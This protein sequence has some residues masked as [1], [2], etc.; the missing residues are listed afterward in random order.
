M[1]L[2]EASLDKLFLKKDDPKKYRGPVPTRDAVL[3]QLANGLNHIHK[4]KLIHRDIKPQNVLIAI[5]TDGTTGRKRPLMKWADFGLSKQVN[6]NGSY[7][8]SGKRG[9]EGWFAPEISEKTNNDEGSQSGNEN[10][11]RGTTKS[12]IFAGGLVFGY[13][14]LDGQH[15]CGK[16]FKTIQ[17]IK[18]E[19]YRQNLN[20]ML[21]NFH[22]KTVYSCIF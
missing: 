21:S 22:Y 14:L 13:F 17:I 9:T 4:M 19:T 20:S 5:E 3:Y 6:E 18:E 2:C 10:K 12:D 1:E 11:K 7:S 16:D 15:L 8:V